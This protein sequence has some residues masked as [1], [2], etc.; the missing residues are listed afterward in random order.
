MRFFYILAIFAFLASCNKKIENKGNKLTIDKVVEAKKQK[1][2]KV[3]SE[4]KLIE[5]TLE[6]EFVYDTISNAKYN[7]HIGILEKFYIEEK[8]GYFTT[9]INGQKDTLNNFLYHQD[10]AAFMLGL[11]P[12]EKGFYKKLTN[13][14][15]FLILEHEPKMLDFGLT[16]WTREEKQLDYFMEHVANPQ[17][18][19]LPIDSIIIIIQRDMGEPN[20]KAKKAK[21]RLIEQL[22]KNK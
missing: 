18:N 3:I 8:R 22:M 17:C 9:F 5:D 15:I 11:D 12:K 16:Q 21:L 6:C 13:K 20:E 7:M 19:T 10:I 14:V 1:S 4:M 2:T